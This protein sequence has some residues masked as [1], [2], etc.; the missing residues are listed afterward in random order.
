MTMETSKI[1]GYGALAFFVACVAFSVS[2][3][4]YFRPE[5]P[6]EDPKYMILCFWSDRSTWLPG[7]WSGRAVYQGR[8]SGEWAV[9]LDHWKPGSGGVK[10]L[11]GYYRRDINWVR[12]G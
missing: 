11:G 10:L 3:W 8:T 6:V 12:P 1:R 4:I 7:P 5:N 9:E 2:L